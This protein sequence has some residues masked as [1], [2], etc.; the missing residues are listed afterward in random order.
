MR[1]ILALVVL[2]LAMQTPCFAAD[3]GN[4]FK[5][6]FKLSMMAERE[7]VT[8]SEL[9]WGC[10]LDAYAEYGVLRIEQGDT[11]LVVGIRKTLDF[12]DKAQS[13]ETRDSAKKD[14]SAAA[15]QF[16]KVIELY[17]SQYKPHI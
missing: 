6:I 1:N 14:T 2:L 9:F 4:A 8:A 11:E 3:P 10:L 16:K 12:Y 7:N 5:F 13:E 15:E 17:R